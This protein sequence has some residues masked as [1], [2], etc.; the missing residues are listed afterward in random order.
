[1]SENAD[2]TLLEHDTSGPDVIES[3]VPNAVQSTIYDVDQSTD[4]DTD[5]SVV[6]EAPPSEHSG[7]VRQGVFPFMKLPSEIRNGIYRLVLVGEKPLYIYCHPICSHPICNG[8]GGNG[9]SRFYFNEDQI[10]CSTLFQVK[11]DLGIFLV[12]HQIW[13]EASSIFYAENVFSFN[14][15]RPGP[16][17]NGFHPAVKRIRK[18]C[19]WTSYYLLG[20]DII[21]TLISEHHVS[22]IAA[23][24]DALVKDHQLQILIID[25]PCGQQGFL[26]PLEYLRGIKRVRVSLHFPSEQKGESMELY[27]CHLRILMMSNGQYSG[28]DDITKEDVM[29]SKALAE[30]GE[31]AK[32]NEQFRRMEVAC[33]YL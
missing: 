17:K 6:S 13:T 26:Q 20:D 30:M 19:L 4:D 27:S 5:E 2:L 15:D 18:C 25:I 3:V 1:M 29:D 28:I 11:K 22:L 33:W 24:A 9:D 10:A 32:M 21:L 14:L 8:Y 23:F 12:S 31:D 7:F 16:R